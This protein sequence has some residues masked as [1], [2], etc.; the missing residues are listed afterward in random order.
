[1]PLS[2]TCRLRIPRLRTVKRC[3]THWKEGRVLC[4]IMLIMQCDLIMLSVWEITRLHVQLSAWEIT[5]EKSCV[6]NHVWEITRCTCNW[7]CE[8]YHTLH[9]QLSAWEITRC[10]CN[11]VCWNSH[12]ARATE[13]SHAARATETLSVQGKL[14]EI[15]MQES[16]VKKSVYEGLKNV[17]MDW[18]F[19]HEDRM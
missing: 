6:R 9:V 13:N 4:K 1:M 5:R 7:V 12:A 14:I 10:T 2:G 15:I 18:L 19:R 11:W 16:H 3:G 8:E 17:I